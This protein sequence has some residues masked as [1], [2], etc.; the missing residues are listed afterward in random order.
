M[1]TLLPT[2]RPPLAYRVP[3][4]VNRTD[5]AHPRVANRSFEPASGVR[6][7]VHDDGSPPG[8]EHWGLVMPGDVHELC[9]CDRDL[10][11]AIVTVAWFRLGDDEEYLWR[12][13]V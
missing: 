10:G 8:S 4:R 3:W 11:S 9:L 13:C 6:A 5:I 2:A 12:F 7:F 1:L